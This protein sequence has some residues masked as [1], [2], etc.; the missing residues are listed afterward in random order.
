MEYIAQVE[1]KESAEFRASGNIKTG[2][3][4]LFGKGEP[5]IIIIAILFIVCLIASIISNIKLTQD[6]K[7]LKEK[8][9][10]VPNGGV[11]AELKA[12]KEKVAATDNR[13]T[14]NFKTIYGKFD[15]FFEF[16]LNYKIENNKT[17]KKRGNK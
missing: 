6:K 9:A 3:F 7:K 10:S 5:F 12:I 14:G 8:I 13:V 16:L 11:Y 15:K 4:E 1:T 17:V 2:A